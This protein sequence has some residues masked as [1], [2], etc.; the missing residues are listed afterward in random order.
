M[1]LLINPAEQ[2]HQAIDTESDRDLLRA[3]A[4]ALSSA[5]QVAHSSQ[6][7]EDWDYRWD[8]MSCKIDGIRLALI[9][10][11]LPAYI[12]LKD[13]FHMLDWIATYHKTH[14]PFGTIRRW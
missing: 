5:W 13:N 14:N 11:D 1:K 9:Y 2:S 8:K 12:E 3:L 7:A 6:Y 4:L 10:F